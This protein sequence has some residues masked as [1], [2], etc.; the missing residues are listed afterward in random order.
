VREIAPGQRSR[1]IGV[2]LGRAARSNK[3]HNA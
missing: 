3:G 2:I 1:V